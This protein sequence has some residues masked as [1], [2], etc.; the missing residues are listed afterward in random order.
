M[1][2]L[3]FLFFFYQVLSAQGKSF[4]NLSEYVIDKEMG[5]SVKYNK[6]TSE[7]I[8]IER[9]KLNSDHPLYI[10]YN[11]MNELLVG[12]FQLDNYKNSECFLVYSPGPSADPAFFFY[13]SKNKDP[14]FSL[15]CEEIIIPSNG[16]IYC[17]NRI[18]RTFAE[19]RK[20]KFNLNKFIEVEQPFYYVGLKTKTNDTITL[21]KDMNL[22]EAVAS[23]PA[24][25]EIE[26]LLN[27]NDLK[28]RNLFL[29]KSSFGLVGWTKIENFDGFGAKPTI[30]ELYFLGD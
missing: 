9:D 23:I 17:N 24:N 16:N 22:S 25:F 30:E 13:D 21:Y 11:E 18:N 19:K 7:L 28:H 10:D 3:Y 26:V 6:S 29:I 15:S 2:I 27:V 20:Y 5:V 14:F 1:K 4:S 12:V 8:N